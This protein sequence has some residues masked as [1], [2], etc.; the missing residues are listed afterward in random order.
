MAKTGRYKLL[1]QVECVET[2]NQ[3]RIVK[4][5]VLDRFETEADALAE[6]HALLEDITEES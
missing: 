3:S 5:E 1:V 2:K 6:F 4:T